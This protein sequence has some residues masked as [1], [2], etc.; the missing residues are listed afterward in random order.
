LDLGSA[1]IGTET[2]TSTKIG[3][4]DRVLGG[5]LVAGSVT[6]LAGE[7]GIGKSTLT[8]QLS[9]LFG[10]D[11]AKTLY[12]SGEESQAQV[13]MRFQRLGI[14]PDAVVFS[15]ATD[16]GSIV[17]AADE[18]SPALLVID[19]IQT[20][21]PEGID[22]MPGT[23]TA[24]RTATA[25]LIGHAKTSGMP[26]V[27]IGQVTKEGSIA[28]PK[29]LEH[30]VDTLLTLEGDRHSSYRLLRASKHRFGG[31]EEVGIFEMMERGM[32]AV[33]NPS[34]RFLEER[35]DVTGSAVTCLMEGSRPILV[36]IQALCEQSQYPNPLRRATGFDSGRLQMLLAIL[37][38]R[39][40]LKTHGLDVYVNVVGG[41]KIKETAADLAVCAAIL[42]SVKDKALPMKGVLIGELGLSGEVRSV[43]RIAYRVK[44]A[45]RL[46]F[47]A[48][49]VK[50]VRDLK[51]LL[52]Q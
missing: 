31:T 28:G 11:K 17:A 45:K 33:E 2:R 40:G 20:M 14:V 12:V 36:E 46:G 10:S 35:Q 8:A 37:N 26:V 13:L 19:S 51:G 6:L 3:E 29:T 7:P 5:G 47:D 9:S 30:L 25:Q 39:A 16:V 1:V 32:V 41:V 43:T 24:V 42:S 50:H 44:E 23:P 15:G 4:L 38:K 48:V 21:I 49:E 27:L 22:S 34:S 18:V 52:G